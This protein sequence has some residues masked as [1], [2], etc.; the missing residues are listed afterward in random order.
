MLF[1]K[2]APSM[3]TAN[4]DALFGYSMQLHHGLFR[5]ASGVLRKMHFTWVQ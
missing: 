4:H 3:N 5:S 2:G 1:K